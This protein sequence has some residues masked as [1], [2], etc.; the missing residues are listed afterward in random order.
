MKLPLEKR[1]K[2]RAHL[3]V[4]RL[5][6]EVMEVLYSVSPHFVFHGGTCIWRCYAGCRFSEDLDLYLSRLPAGFQSALS[7]ALL[8]RGL[9][10]SKFKQTESLVFCKIQ[11]PEAEMRVEINFSKCP[12]AVPM[13]YEKMDGSALI[14]NAVPL[15]NLIIEKAH[16]Y[17][18]RRSI[19]D[20]YDVYF[21][22]A[23]MEDKKT[24][25][26]LASMIRKFQPPA[27]ESNLAA[28]VY[29]GV[30]PSFS[31]MLQALK[32]RFG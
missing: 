9:S 1:L 8:S 21:L 24:A 27:D 13:P 11:S 2:K 23:G 7:A 12:P 17:L 28:I 18:G 29:S 5:Q 20:I 15:S 19:R 31:A 30:A 25:H 10:I 26:E 32:G 22:S 6:D 16:A 3:A 14:V 4:G